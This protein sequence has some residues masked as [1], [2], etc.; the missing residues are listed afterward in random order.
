MAHETCLKCG[1]VIYGDSS[2]LGKL[3]AEHDRRM[4]EQG[5][6]RA[7]SWGK[8]CYCDGRGKDVYG[9]TCKYCNGSGIA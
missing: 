3:M 6:R 7:S 8:C 2:V 9:I 1:Q 4:H 5:W